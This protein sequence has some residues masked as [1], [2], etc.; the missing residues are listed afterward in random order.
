MF[1]FQSLPN[2]QIK[3]KTA[4][5]LVG[6]TV[7]GSSSVNGMFFDRPSRHDFEALAEAS[8]S[9][10]GIKWDWEGVFGC[11]KKVSV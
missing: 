4:Q 6:K 11:F 8:G 7:G 1:Y 3:N 5:P 2:L 9:E 10:G